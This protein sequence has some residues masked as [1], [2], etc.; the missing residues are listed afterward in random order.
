MAR[1]QAGK[2]KRTVAGLDLGRLYA[3]PAARALYERI[4]RELAR[5]YKDRRHAP[6][7]QAWGASGGKTRAANLSPAKRQEIARAAAKAR[8]ASKGGKRRG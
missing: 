8:W 7:F 1:K 3:Q 6:L 2:L 4:G 5:V